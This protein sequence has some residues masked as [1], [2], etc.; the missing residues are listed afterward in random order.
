MKAGGKGRIFL[1]CETSS[2]LTRTWS[3][4]VAKACASQSDGLPSLDWPWFPGV[5]RR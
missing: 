3:H 5:E 4:R 2:P 1:K